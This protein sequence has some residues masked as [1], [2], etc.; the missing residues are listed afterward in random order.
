MAL[1]ERALNLS[2]QERKLSET[3]VTEGYCWAMTQAGQGE[4]SYTVSVPTGSL[5]G[6]V[7][8]LR[9]GSEFL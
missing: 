2:L 6:R 4:G 9:N 8:R 5:F 3:R 1:L 7:T